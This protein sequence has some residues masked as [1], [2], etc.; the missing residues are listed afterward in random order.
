MSTTDTTLL[1]ILTVLLSLYFLLS[2]IAVFFI[3]K[4]L[5]NVRDITDKAVKVADSVESAAEDLRSASSKIAVFK[6]LSNIFDMG[7][8]K[9]GGKHDHE[10]RS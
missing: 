7:K 9:R 4:I 3:I 5:R 1:I 10:S 6:V 8:S 2:S